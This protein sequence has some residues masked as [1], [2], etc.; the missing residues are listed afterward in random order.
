MVNTRGSCISFGRALDCATYASAAL[1]G[2]NYANTLLSTAGRAGRQS[3]R[4]ASVPLALLRR[5]VVDNVSS[6]YAVKKAIR[7]EL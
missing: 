1:A 7:I 2:H 6:A 3:K 4:S 5:P